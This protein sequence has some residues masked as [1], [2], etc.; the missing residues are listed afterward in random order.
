M[1]MTGFF[2]GPKIDVVASSGMLCVTI[3]PR[4]NLQAALAALG[5]DVIF[6]VVLYRVWSAIPFSIRI[7][8]LALLPFILLSSVYEFFG[9]EIVEIDSQKLTIRKG[10]HGW[11]RKREYQI[12]EC[13]NLEWSAGRKGGSHLTCKVGRWPITF[14]KRLSETDGDEIFLA[15]QRTLPDVA[16]KICTSTGNKEH[17]ITL[18]L[19]R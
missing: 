4:P 14:A 16:Q 11:E 12:D 9:E 5:G 2:D 15:L 19:R 6:P 13:S 10:I 1:V 7:V 17:F 8:W 3:H 18:G